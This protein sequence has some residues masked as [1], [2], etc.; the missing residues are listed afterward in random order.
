MSTDWNGIIRQHGST[1]FGAAWRILGHASDAEDVVQ[2]VFL[3]AQQL[4]NSQ[5]VD[6]WAALLRRM[7]TY[8]ALDRLRRRKRALSL[9]G[10]PMPGKE[11]GPE[12]VAV[13]REL[14]ARLR[15]AITQLPNREA[16]VFSLRFFEDLSYEQ[17]AESLGVSTSAVAPALHKARAKLKALLVDPGGEE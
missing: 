15:T 2:E 5:S 9:D 13:G 16:A 3:E 7:A 14:E 10:L 11:H 4:A 12:A 8:R 17:I 1:V 6:H